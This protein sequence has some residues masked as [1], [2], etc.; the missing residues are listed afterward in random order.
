MTVYDAILT[1]LSADTT[2]LLPQ[3]PQIRIIHALICALLPLLIAQSQFYAPVA[4]LGE[5]RS[6]I[7]NTWSDFRREREASG[8]RAGSPHQGRVKQRT[9]E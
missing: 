3:T 6:K 5:R 7:A 2:K 9:L 8:R 4:Q 1:M